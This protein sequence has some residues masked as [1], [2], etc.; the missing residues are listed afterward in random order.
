M[1]DPMYQYSLTWFRNLFVSSVKTSEHPLTIQERIEVL[2]DHFMFS[3]YRNVCRSLFE[4]HKLLF[5]FLMAVKLLQGDGK[6]DAQEW[7]FLISG[8]ASKQDG[9]GV[10]GDGGVAEPSA[11]WVDTRM[12]AELQALSSLP[13]FQ[14]LTADFASNVPAWEAVFDSAEAHSHR[15]PAPWNEKLNAMQKMCVLRCIRP[16]K[17]ALAIQEFVAANFGRRFIEP[18][19]LD[20]RSCF[21]DSTVVTPLI[22]I[23]STGS[24][25]TKTFYNF[26]DLM[27]CRRKVSCISL[28]QGQ[29]AV[30]ARMIAEAQVRGCVGC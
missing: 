13:A 29:G 27:N 2:N 15:L 10:E 25:P 26:A 4:R 12:W 30:A 3:I 8:Q 16:D 24:D 17:M 14:G 23:L 21:E 7:R 9:G 5:S 28:G 20:L 18:P 22:F 6:V 19:P 11:A 1:V